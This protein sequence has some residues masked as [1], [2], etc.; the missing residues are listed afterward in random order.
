VASPGKTFLVYRSSA[1]SGKTFTLVKE[2]L[3]IALGEDP[4]AFRKILAI[5]FTNKAAGEMKERVLK[6]LKDLSQNNEKGKFLAALLGNEMQV[7]EHVLQS[8][9]ELVLKK[10]MHNYGDFSIQTIDSFIH[11]ITKTFALDLRLPPRF[12]VELNTE[13]LIQRAVDKMLSGL[14]PDTP[15]SDFLVEFQK[16]SLEEEESTRIEE[17]LK[18]L[19]LD[20]LNEEE[21][22]WLGEIATYTY[23][24]FLDAGEEIKKLEKEFTEKA[25]RIGSEAIR[26]IESRGLHT[27]DLSYGK[28]GY[29]I[30]FRRLRD[31]TLEGKEPSN[32]AKKPL[33]TDEWASKSAGPEALQSL[34][35]I[36]DQLRNFMLEGMELMEKDYPLYNLRSNLRKNLYTTGL[37]KE[38]FSVAESIKEE[39][40]LVLIGEMNEKIS[41]IVTSQPGPFIFER[42]GEKYKHFLVDEFQDTSRLQWK[43]LV[44]LLQNGISEGHLSLLVGDG[45]QAIYRWRG[46]EVSQFTRLPELDNPEKNPVIQERENLLKS[47]FEEKKLVRN[48]R[49]RKEIIEFNNALFGF[50]AE[51]KF[52][53]ETGEVF[54]ELKQEF[55]PEHTG[56]KVFFKW[57]I[58]EGQ[59]DDLDLKA[60]EHTRETIAGLLAEGYRY[61]DI[62]LLTRNKNEVGWLASYLI[63]FGIPVITSDSLLLSESPEIQLLES[64]FEVVLNPESKISRLRFLKNYFDCHDA[65]GMNR[66]EQFH[67]AAEKDRFFSFLKDLGIH[68]SPPALLRLPLYEI[69]EEVVRQCGLTKNFNPYVCA[70]L[71]LALEFGSVRSGSPAAFLQWFSTKK[72]N[73]SLSIPENLNAVR[74]MT[75]HKSKGLEFPV[76]LV[77]FCN[78]DTSKMGRMAW[79]DLKEHALGKIKISLVKIKQDLTLTPFAHLYH[80]EK[81]KTI[82]DNLNLLYVAF[83]RPTDRLYI[84][85]TPKGKARDLSPWL[86]DFLK[87]KGLYDSLKQDYSFGAKEAAKPVR[88]EKKEK[89]QENINFLS[90]PWQGKIFTRKRYRSE[91]LPGLGVSEKNDGLIIHAALSFLK[92][93]DEIE[94]AVETVFRKGIIREPEKEN[95]QKILVE[96]LSVDEIRKFF[97]SGPGVLT[98]REIVIPEGGTLRPDRLLFFKDKTLIVDFKTGAPKAADEAQVQEYKKILSEAGYP[99]PEAWLIYTRERRA[100]RV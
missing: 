41:D 17:D 39:E 27:S 2:Y 14:L 34:K 92:S 70:F 68:L 87:E 30:F 82:L 80:R 74:A 13:N 60:L 90:S 61:A 75:I 11:R 79:A 93:P 64:A 98:E 9:A 95:L 84:F 67:Q 96:I 23:Q 44:P 62:C 58:P 63:R 43:N 49:S 99:V 16:R 20:L 7:P 40:S 29:Y 22:S 86:E 100:K 3:K 46:G 26:L 89:P 1:G 45:K 81:S 19:A 12:E 71:D 33:D 76:V 59:D 53:E 37:V 15:L 83:T 10:I 51:K 91:A 5:T 56:G 36:K 35:S 94:A 85:T 18:K 54:R 77:P 66:E 88:T 47:S 57:L 38:I 24:D 65:G 69:A 6:S 31:N 48:F 52:P 32:N 42:L 73:A 21:K 8:R 97:E 28:H 78:W 25:N 55:N 72:E 50:L 4:F